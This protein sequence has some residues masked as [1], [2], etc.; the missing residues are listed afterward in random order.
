MS[1]SQ[2]TTELDSMALVFQHMDEG[3][4]KKTKQNKTERANLMKGEKKFLFCILL[5]LWS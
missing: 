3:V 5:E 2:T 1:L 4:T